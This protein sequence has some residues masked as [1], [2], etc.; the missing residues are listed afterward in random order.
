M[1]I[2]MLMGA[3]RDR[4]GSAIEEFEHTYLMDKK[5]RYPKTLHDRYTLLKSWKKS[6]SR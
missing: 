5:N 3:D 4:F 2:H 1:V 6:G